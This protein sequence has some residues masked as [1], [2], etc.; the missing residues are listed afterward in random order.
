MSYEISLQNYLEANDKEL[1]GRLLHVGSAARSLLSYTQN[2]FPFYT[3]HDFFHSTTVEENLNWLIPDK[4]KGELNSS[5]IF[6]LICSAWLHDW[7]MIGSPDEEA[8]FVREN[9]HIRTETNL[10]SMHDLVGLSS[11]E[12][13]IIGRICKGHRKV[14]LYSKEFDDK[15]L[16]Q[17]IRIRTRFLSALLRIADETDVTH[18]RTPEV[19]YYSLNPTGKSEEEFKKHLAISGVGQL[20]EPHKIY[21]TAIARDP[22][23]AHTLREVTSKIQR[24]LD[25]VKGILSQNGI[26]LDV[27]ELRMETRG[28]I[29]KPIAFEVNR[30]NLV[31]LLIGKHLYGS[32]D[33]ALRELIQNSIDACKMKKC[34]VANYQPSIFVERKSSSDLTISDNGAGMSY[35]EAKEFLSNVGTSFYESEE[36]KTVLPEK[37]FDPISHFGI[38]LLSAF[39]IADG[40][41][42]ETKKE[43]EDA[44]R[45]TILSLAEDW[46]YE[47]GSLKE[48]G[49]KIT[50]HLN[51]LGKE[52]RISES[53]DKYFISPGIQ[54]SYSEENGVIKNFDGSWEVCEI[55]ER[56]LKDDEI[57]ETESYTKILEFSNKD[58]DCY[59]VQSSTFRG[60]QF[61]LFNQGVF[62]R[63]IHINGLNDHFHVFLNLKSKAI[64]LHI[65]RENIVY[66]EKWKLFQYSLFEKMLENLRDV[67]CKN[68][69]RKFISMLSQLIEARL[70]ID[71]SDVKEINEYPF[72][73]SVMKI[74]LFPFLKAG[75][76]G[77][78]TFEEIIQIDVKSLYSCSSPNYDQEIDAY[79]KVLKKEDAIFNPYRFPIFYEHDLNNALGMLNF[80]AKQH[81]IELKKTN[82][83]NLLLKVAK[84]SKSDYSKILPKK[85]KLA[86]FGKFNPIVV[87]AKLPTASGIQSPF[88]RYFVWSQVFWENLSQSGRHQLFLEHFRNELAGQFSEDFQTPEILI[89]SNDPFVASIIENY[90]VLTPSYCEDLIRYFK[91]LS[92]LPWIIGNLQSSLIL[93]EVLDELEKTLSTSIGFPRP[94]V[95]FNRMKPSRDLYFQYFENHSNIET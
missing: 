65:S 17:S 71:S 1:F 40:L 21:I 74:A 79:K 69:K 12:A 56:F 43:G 84:V 5:E 22:K 36:F 66:N 47:K 88:H 24:E 68:D 18:S 39:L 89:D 49:T 78:G 7:G 29:D 28:F 59:L 37:S 85:I 46:K 27:V 16:G 90:A 62:V 55:A 14:D 91:Y 41:V 13:I 81:N 93:V 45:F 63:K 57:G 34:L 9:H 75:K 23:G 60:G 19:I 38:G 42:I 35:F 76:I 25:G 72:L 64:D 61:V 31:E 51:D 70:L 80:Y 6:F 87:V 95:M 58:F 8:A 3:P 86:T 52:V 33:V 67:V 82:L 11:H 83:R 30:H 92:L 10:E 53:L 54:I 32:V 48:S 4:V 94:D 20:D 2:K 50:M 44:C 26:S 77:Y 15:I 73:A